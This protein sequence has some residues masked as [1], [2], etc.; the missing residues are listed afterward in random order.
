M[1][2]TR[3]LLLIFLIMS[4]SFIAKGCSLL[5][6]TSLTILGYHLEKTVDEEGSLTAGIVGSAVNDGSARLEYAEIEGSF[7]S[8]DGT[9]L[10]TGF[11]TTISEEDQPFTLDPH[12]IW[13]FTISYSR[14]AHPS[15]NILSWN[16][17]KDS[18][19]TRIEGQAQNNGD[20]ILSFAEITGT[21]YSPSQTKLASG[22]ATTTMLGVGEVWQFV[23]PYAGPYAEKIGW[24]TV[25]VTETDYEPQ[26]AQDVDHVTAEVGSLR[27]STLMP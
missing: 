21:F 27:G 13:V 17:K 8:Q 16:L 2:K 12:E 18:S 14:D 1:D 26:P 10:A 7:Y 6:T 11:A 20:V 4:V 24:V 22:T 25:E 5:P 3:L 23:I 15:L 19:G 9:L